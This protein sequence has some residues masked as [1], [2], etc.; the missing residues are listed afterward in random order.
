MPTIRTYQ[1]ATVQPRSAYQ[2]WPQ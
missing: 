1:I 2:H